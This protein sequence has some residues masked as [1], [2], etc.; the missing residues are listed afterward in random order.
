MKTLEK[1]IT[2]EEFMFKRQVG[3][4]DI[5]PI[6]EKPAEKEKCTEFNVFK[7]E[8]D[9]MINLIPKYS[10]DPMTMFKEISINAGKNLNTIKKD[11]FVKNGFVPE[12]I[13]NFKGVKYRQNFKNEFLYDFISGENP[14]TT[15]TK[16]PTIYTNDLMKLADKL[17]MV[18]FPFEYMNPESYDE[19]YVSR[20]V[21]NFIYNTK[22]LAQELEL[23]P[24]VMAPISQYSLNRHIYAENANMDIYTKQFETVFMSI[25]MNIPIFKTIIKDIDNIKERM[26]S[27]ETAIDNIRANIKSIEMTIERLEQKMDYERKQVFVQNNKMFSE[28]VIRETDFTIEDPALFLMPKDFMVKNSVAYLGTVW[29]PDFTPAVV[30]CLQ[31]KIIDGQKAKIVKNMTHRSIQ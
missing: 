5:L 12:N 20:N 10:I 19:Y 25:A 31:L 15:L 6:I 14:Y 16:C 8:L 4:L 23:I 17:G 29:G 3:I 13:V 28:E 21:N 9:T 30:E 11:F 7:K 2:S 27:M 24:Y 18:I 1:Q 26:D 22:E